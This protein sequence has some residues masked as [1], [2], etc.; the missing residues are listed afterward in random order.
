MSRHRRRV[1]RE[2]GLQ[3][4]NAN[5]APGRACEVGVSSAFEQTTE[6]ASRFWRWGWLR[7]R[8]RSITQ[9][10]EA[11]H[12][13]P[14]ARTRTHGSSD[15]IVCAPVVPFHSFDGDSE[16]IQDS[17]ESHVVRNHHTYKFSREWTSFRLLVL[18]FVRTACA[19]I[20]PNEGF[21]CKVPPD[22]FA[23]CV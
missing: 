13:L 21:R 6:T 20:R 23:G 11:K 5:E 10:I 4:H 7:S 16:R 15:R 3:R 1:M 2:R 8:R 22:D 9:P 12:F 14:R 18:C 19:T 17:Q